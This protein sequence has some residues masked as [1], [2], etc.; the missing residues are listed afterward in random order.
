V[1]LEDLTYTVHFPVNGM[2]SDPHIW[3]AA[4]VTSHAVFKL[5]II[6]RYGRHTRYVAENSR[7]CITSVVIMT[8]VCHPLL[9][10]WTQE[11]RQYPERYISIGTF[12]KIYVYITFM[13]MQNDDI[14]T[15][16]TNGS[17]CRNSSIHINQRTWFILT[18]FVLLMEWCVTRRYE[19]KFYSS[20]CK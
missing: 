4:M 8:T 3:H 11:V 1:S 20:T 17:R 18:A 13:S 5:P 9:C 12:R 7:M 16:T 15:C 6:H 14:V 2:Y 10:W 19:L